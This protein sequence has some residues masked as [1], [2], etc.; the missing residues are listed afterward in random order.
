MSTVEEQERR[1][2]H[3]RHFLIPAGILIG[4]G[5]GLITGYPGPGILIGL[6][7]GFLA[8]GFLR[9]VESLAPDQAT[10]CCGH[11]DRWISVM[12]GLFLIIIGIGIIW[13]PAHIWPYVIGIF[14]ILLGIMF[15]AKSWQK[16]A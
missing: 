12:I 13:I 9:P 3:G 10:P 11:G 1:R 5:V 6:G 7:L 4:L 14:L 8:Q 15:A 2:R 16:S